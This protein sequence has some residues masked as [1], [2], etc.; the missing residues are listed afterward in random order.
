MPVEN[1]IQPAGKYYVLAPLSISYHYDPNK[2]V[3]YLY[4]LQ[5]SKA[6]R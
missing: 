1:L 4:V 3:K 5:R 2:P 6:T